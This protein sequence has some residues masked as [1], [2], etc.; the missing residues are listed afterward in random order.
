MSL[1]VFVQVWCEIDPTLNVRVD[2]QTGSAVADVGDRLWRVSMQG[3][4]GVAAAVR[5]GVA[6]ITAFAL[7]DG[8]TEALRHALA[9]GA[10]RAVGL[11]TEGGDAAVLSVAHIAEWLRGQQADLVIADRLAGL[12][13][14]RLGWAHLAGLDGLE[15]HAGLLRAVR[16]LGRGDREEV[17]ARLPAAVRLQGESPRVP[18]VSRARL[19]AVAEKNIERQTLSGQA[20]A[21]G[22][23]GPLHLAR[24]R[25]RL[26]QAPVAA[27]TSASDR[28][29]ALLGGQSPAGASKVA[30]DG[31][32]TP[33]QL[34]EE[35]VRYLLHHDLL[36]PSSTNP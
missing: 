14:A 35:L 36:P 30:Q 33:D 25:T 15:I 9:G 21:P 22:D 27:S 11:Q 13:A 4:A 2:R 18:Y 28:L 34:A 10:T 1:R 6:S 16:H 17:S 32:Q 12:V 26:G 24:A 7:G 5:L 8:Q 23:V 20:T 19:Q 31:A 3:R 29:Q